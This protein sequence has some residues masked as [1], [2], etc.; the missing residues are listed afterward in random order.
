MLCGV[1]T[2]QHDAAFQAAAVASLESLL[3]ERRIQPEVIQTT[4]DLHDQVSMQFDILVIFLAIMAVLIIVVAGIG[5][6]GTMSINIMER[7]TELGVLRAL[8]AS[9]GVLMRIIIFE[10]VMSSLLSWAFAGLLAWPL[11]N[12]LWR[13]NGA[14]TNECTI[15]SPNSA[16]E[17][18][19]VWLVIAVLVGANASLL[20]AIR[21]S[22]LSVREVL[23]YE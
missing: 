7:I 22:R 17:G 15:N 12:L 23:S 10:G 20:P 1:V 14:G 6:A 13:G 2:I 4:N 11:S 16:V 5:M 8:G 21:A 9:R 3:E 19:F 18:L